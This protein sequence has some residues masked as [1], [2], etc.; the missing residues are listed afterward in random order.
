MLHN[1]YLVIFQAWNLFYIFPNFPSTALFYFYYF[2][3]V[4]SLIKIS[5]QYL[6]IVSDA[7]VTSHTGRGKTPARLLLSLRGGG[8]AANWTL[9]GISGTSTVSTNFLATLTPTFSL[10]YLV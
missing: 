8:R 3:H 10:F 4:N 9:S 6:L 2:A 7:G 1:L 5:E